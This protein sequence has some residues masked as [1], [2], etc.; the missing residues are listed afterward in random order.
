MAIIDLIYHSY[1]FGKPTCR[2][3]S[4]PVRCRTD[5]LLHKSR[6]GIGT[7][8]HEMLWLRTKLGFTKLEIP[9]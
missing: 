2:L 4:T 6:L 5:R 1:Y 9:L 7:E 8:L 3:V